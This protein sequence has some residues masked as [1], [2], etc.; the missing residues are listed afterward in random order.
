MLTQV[1]LVF[2]LTIN[3]IDARGL[4]SFFFFN[5]YR[6]LFHLK[7]I[8]LNIKKEYQIFF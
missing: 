3:Y 8:F 7:I 2:N 5:I 6:G 1:V 4:S